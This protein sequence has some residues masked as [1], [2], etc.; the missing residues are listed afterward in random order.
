MRLVDRRFNVRIDDG[1][2]TVRELHERPAGRLHDT[3]EMPIISPL[4]AGDTD[5]MPRPLPT[6]RSPLSVARR[7]L[8]RRH[9]R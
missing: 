7:M 2:V 5:A 4:V 1:I 9:Q 8:E 3:S 6:R